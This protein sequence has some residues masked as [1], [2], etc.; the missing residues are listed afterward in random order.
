MLFFDACNSFIFQ[1]DMTPSSIGMGG[2]K[3]CERILKIDE[4]EY[5]TGED[6]E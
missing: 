4:I 2:A 3:T 6:D 5:T 1:M